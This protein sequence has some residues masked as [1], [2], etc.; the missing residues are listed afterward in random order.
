MPSILVSIDFMSVFFPR[1]P[2]MN[3]D[4]SVCNI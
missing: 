1:F 3:T 4:V 2:V